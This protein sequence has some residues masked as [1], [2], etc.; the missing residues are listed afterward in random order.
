MN[1]L[2]LELH[3]TK[4]WTKIH[5]LWEDFNLGRLTEIYYILLIPD[6]DV[7]LS[8]CEIAIPIKNSPKPNLN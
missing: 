3:L 8:P 1:V 7:L 2:S 5:S 6:L 4:N